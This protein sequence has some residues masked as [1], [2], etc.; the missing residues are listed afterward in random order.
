MFEI[1]IYIPRLVSCLVQ[2]FVNRDT[3]LTQGRHVRARSRCSTP[4]NADLKFVTDTLKESIEKQ[5]IKHRAALR[6]LVDAGC[7]EA[8]PSAV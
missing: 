6:H 5:D 8:A 2:Y 3:L 1:E 4:L 7:A